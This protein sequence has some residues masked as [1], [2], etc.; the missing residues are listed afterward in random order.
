MVLAPLSPVTDSLLD[1]P[2]PMM[3]TNPMT[4][5]PIAVATATRRLVRGFLT[6]VLSGTDGGIGSDLMRG[7]GAYNNV[8]FLE[9]L[10]LGVDP[11]DLSDEEARAALKKNLIPKDD[12]RIRA[13]LR[14]VKGKQ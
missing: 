13:A 11:S 12:I 4:A 2:H 14:D 5:R 1:S 3:A 9:V 6:S 10:Y 7:G 8:V